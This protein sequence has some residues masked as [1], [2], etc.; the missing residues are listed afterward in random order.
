M[1]DINTKGI[2]LLELYKAYFS[3]EYDLNV[4]ELCGQKEQ[5]IKIF[6]NLVDQLKN[7][8]LI[9]S[10]SIG[11][12]VL[13]PE[14][15]IYAETNKIPPQED[16]QANT[17]ARTLILD[18]LANVYEEKGYQYELS[19]YE[20]VEQT[21]L[22]EIV[23]ERNLRFLEG[24]NYV[25]YYSVGY[26]KITQPGLD[27]VEDYRKRK[28]IGDEF[29]VISKQMPQ[30]RGRALQ[31]IIGKII[32]QNGWK[33][34][35]GV[36]TSHEEMDVIVFKEREF[37]L[38]ECK[39]E[40]EPI[41]AKVIR[42]IFGKLG[43]RIDVREIVVSMSGF[44]SGAIEQTKEYVGQ[45]VILLFGRKSIESMIYTDTSFDEL[46]NEKYKELIMRKRVLSE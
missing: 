34:E 30:P 27:A 42:E 22:S 1:K 17:Q 6:G 2:I 15:I 28:G 11:S 43:N 24:L 25:E 4:Y 40:K 9:E 32:E 46:L 5:E 14:G 33:Q 19:I 13:T 44:T 26:F 45:K 12:Y 31:K 16:I 20:I 36:K 23:T 3:P 39:W 38:L 7:K 21:G 35:E 37:Y 18:L 8:Y 10:F 41:E 29:A